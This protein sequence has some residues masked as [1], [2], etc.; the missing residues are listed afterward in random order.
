MCGVGPSFIGVGHIILL[1]DS[2]VNLRSLMETMRVQMLLILKEPALIWNNGP[3]FHKL[4]E[5]LGQMQKV[6][7]TYLAAAAWIKSKILSFQ[8]CFAI[9][10]YR[11]HHHH[12]TTNIIIRMRECV[13]TNIYGQIESVLTRQEPLCPNPYAADSFPPEKSE[14]HISCVMKLRTYIFINAPVNI[15]K[16]IPLLHSLLFKMVYIVL[17]PFWMTKPLYDRSQPFVKVLLKVWQ[18]DKRRNP[19][20]GD[21]MK[22]ASKLWMLILKVHFISYSKLYWVE[23]QYSMLNIYLC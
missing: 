13:W 12:T 23:G 19:K 1:Q 11:C 21:C 15:E 6:S 2:F 22:Y 10:N 14:L 9:L 17:L 20:L 18:E 7:F 8:F 4:L 5:N 16:N 3:I